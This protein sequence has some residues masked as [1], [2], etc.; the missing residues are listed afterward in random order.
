[1]NARLL[2][3]VQRQAS[4]VAAFLFTSLDSADR[5][6]ELTQPVLY[7]HKSTTIQIYYLRLVNESVC[8]CVWAQYTVERTIIYFVPINQQP[9][10]DAAVNNNNEW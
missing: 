9:A 5:T 10:C 7:M 3:L 8:V 6:S 1:M 4:F 2:F